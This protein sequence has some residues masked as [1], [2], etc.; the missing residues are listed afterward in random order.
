SPRRRHAKFREGLPLLLVALISCGDSTP[1]SWTRQVAATRSCDSD[2]G[3]G[4]TLAARGPA[5][6][7]TDWRSTFRRSE[8]FGLSV[9]G[10]KLQKGGGLRMRPETRRRRMPVRWGTMGEAAI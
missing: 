3:G 9:G 1:V 8:Y 2:S 7:C 10:L 5:R 4:K 6:F